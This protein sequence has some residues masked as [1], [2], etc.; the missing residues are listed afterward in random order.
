MPLF[1]LGESYG[2]KYVSA[3][4]YKLMTEAKNKGIITGLKGIII[5]DGFNAPWK[6]FSEVGNHAFSMGLLD[7]QERMHI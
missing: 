2:G 3:L 1:L 4:G 6:I 5:A 7:Y